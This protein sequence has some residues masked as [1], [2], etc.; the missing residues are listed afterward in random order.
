MRPCCFHLH[1]LLHDQ[2]S[3]HQPATIA[4][5]SYSFTHFLVLQHVS[6]IL[7]HLQPFI[8]TFSYFCKPPPNYPPQSNSPWQPPTNI[9][10]S[11]HSPPQQPLNLPPQPQLSVQD[12]S[13]TRNKKNSDQDADLNNIGDL[14]AH[15]L[16]HVGITGNTS[17]SAQQP[18]LC[19]DTLETKKLSHTRSNSTNADGL[20]HSDEKLGAASYSRKNQKGFTFQRVSDEYEGR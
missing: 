18:N 16:Q 1:Y 15:G 19:D 13:T 4:S 2:T 3:F 9:P 6:S 17:S 5:S 20:A 7:S 12:P 11:S 8:A 14:K 10:P